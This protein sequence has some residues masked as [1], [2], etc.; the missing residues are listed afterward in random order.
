[1]CAVQEVVVVTKPLSPEQKAANKKAREGK[2]KGSQ[3]ESGKNRS[4]LKTKTAPAKVVEQKVVP[5]KDSLKKEEKSAE[6]IEKEKEETSITVKYDLDRV[7]WKQHDQAAKKKYDELLRQFIEVEK[8]NQIILQIKAQPIEPF[9]IEQ[10]VPRGNSES[11]AVIVASDWHVEE[12]VDP[13][14]VNDMNEY[15]LDISKARAAAFFR[16]ALRLIQIHGRDTHIKT[17]IL[18]LLGD[19]ISGHIHP[20][21]V[22]SNLLLPMDAIK[23]AEQYLVSG[24]EFLLKNGDFDIVIPCHTGNH[25]RGTDKVHFATER[26]HSLEFIMYSN[27]QSYFRKHKRV[28]FLIAQGYHTYLPVYDKVVRFHH[29]HAMR[30]KDGVGGIT[31]PINK[32]ISKWNNAR[33]VHLD[34]FGHFHQLTH[35]NHFI[36]NGSLIGWSPYAISIGAAYERPQQAFFLIHSKKWLIAF[37]PI[38]VEETQT[39]G[40]G[41]QVPE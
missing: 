22:E 30:Y 3:K 7:R 19:F 33:T 16:N 15:N 35:S 21:L 32:R 17:V 14:T 24:I 31:I 18:A 9:A 5:E 34:V 12:R 36:C 39:A 29:G 11:T 40:E 4:V 6:E 23:R 2:K 28:K 25:G 10:K 13:S 1:V 27:M 37:A 8:E 20:E 26:G 41:I 38:L